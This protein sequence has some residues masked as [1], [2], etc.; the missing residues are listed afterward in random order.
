MS[1][2]FT[3]QTPLSLILQTCTSWMVWGDRYP[4]TETFC[5]GTWRPQAI[6]ASYT[7]C[8]LQMSWSPH[9][10][11]A[12]VRLSLSTNWWHWYGKVIGKV[13]G[14]VDMAKLIQ[15][16]MIQLE[17]GA[18]KLVQTW[19]IHSGPISMAWQFSYAIIQAN[20]LL[21]LLLHHIVLDLFSTR[22]SRTPQCGPKGF[23]INAIRRWI[24]L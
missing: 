15:S 1:F 23:Q 24:R 21:Q 9:Q 5:L 4:R 7:S 10:V 11:P 8:W 18:M 19:T 20:Q 12:R 17:I 13:I 14:K 2:T 6:S 3:S 16:W 22:G